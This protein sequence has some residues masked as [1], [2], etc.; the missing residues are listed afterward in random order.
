MSN[1]NF[2]IL[3]IT[4]LFWVVFKAMSS[5][6]WLSW[7]RTFPELPLFEVL[8]FIP[9]LASDGVAILSLLFMVV[10]FFKPNRVFLIIV[11]TLELLLMSL[12]QMRWQ[13]TLFQFMMTL[14]I[15]ILKPRSFKFYVML[16]LSATYVF[17]GLHKFNLGF[18]NFVWAKFFLV[19]TMGVSTEI[20]YSRVVKALGFLLPVLEIVGGILIWTRFQTRG[21]IL[22]IS[23]HVLL[24][25]ALGPFGSNYNSIVWPWNMM[26]ILLAFLF[27]KQESPSFNKQLL[28]NSRGVI[29]SIIIG[30]LPILGFIGKYP[31]QFSFDLYSGKMSYLYVDTSCVKIIN[32]DVKTIDFEQKLYLSVFNWSM[33]ELNVPVYSYAPLLNNFKLH[34]NQNCKESPPF[35]IRRYPYNTETT[36]PF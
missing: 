9:S 4:A 20:A 34:Y 19:D 1:F 11:F 17:S 13:P 33:Q 14:L 8:T 36:V 30:V 25:L 35:I 31:P 22:L 7:G 23:M 5:H 3:R 26:M 28:F 2:W 29:L 24:L 6:L 16:L 10:A 32:T 15:F 21:W 12:D 18:S 27:L